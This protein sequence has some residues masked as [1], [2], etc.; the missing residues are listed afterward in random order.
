MQ[1][2]NK[3]FDDIAKVANSAAGTFA[4]L[5]EEIENMVRHKVEKLLTDNNMVARDEFEAVKAMVVEARKEQ[6]HLNKTL[7]KI[8]ILLTST[9]KTKQTKKRVSAKR[10]VTKKK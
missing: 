2:R 10:K 3:L 1:T 9:Q 7:A 6:D 5:K 4:G 8:E